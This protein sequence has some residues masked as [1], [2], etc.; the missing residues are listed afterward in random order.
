MGINYLWDTNTAIYYL[1]QQ[2]PLAAEKFIDELLLNS[3]PCIS[4][5]T[6][7]ELLCWKSTNEEELNVLHNFIK[8]CFVIELEQSIKIKT[9]EIRKQSKIKLPDAIIAATAIVYDLTMIT[10]NISDF[11]SIVGFKIVDLFNI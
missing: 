8:D 6:E 9:A 1:Q 7:I 11:K 2:L 3:Q 4:A 5:I 10:R